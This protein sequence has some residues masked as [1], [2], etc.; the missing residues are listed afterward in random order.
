MCFG[1]PGG[2][3]WSERL[4]GAALFA[5]SLLRYELESVARK[6]CRAHPDQGR[7][8]LLAVSL[9]LDPRRGIV[10]IDPDPLDVVLL[11]TATGLTTDDASYLCLAGM[12]DADLVTRDASLAAALDP[13]AGSGGV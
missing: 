5:P 4:D 10:W 7:A 2:E 6:K 1:E 11:A 12:L 8:I 3:A 9:A 13:Y